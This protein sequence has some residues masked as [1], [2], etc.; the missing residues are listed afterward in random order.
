MSSLR[1]LVTIQNDDNLC[2]PQVLVAARVH[3]ILK[4]Q[5]CGA[6]RKEWQII[7]DSRRKL[8]KER[9]EKLVNDTGV[10]LPYDG[11]GFRELL[12]FQNFFVAAG[13]AIVVYEIQNL[14][15]GEAPLFDGRNTIEEL[16]T[17]HHGVIYLIFEERNRHFNFITN[18]FAVAGARFFVFIAIKVIV[19]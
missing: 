14:G 9:T 5:D 18:L 16:N 17:P 10:F 19:A 7:R 6:T 15:N 13:I 4:T 12:A 3:L 8:Q 11:C 1:S 2:L